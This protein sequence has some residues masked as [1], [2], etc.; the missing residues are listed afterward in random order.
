MRDR[1]VAF[2]LAKAGVSVVGIDRS[3][4]MLARARRRARRSEVAGPR[5]P[6]PRRHPAPAVPGRPLP[7]GD[8]A[9]T[10]SC[11]R[12]CA[13]GICGHARLGGGR[14]G[15]G[16]H[17]GLELVADLPSWEEYRRR[18]ACAAGRPAGSRITLV[19]SVRQ[20]RARRL[21]L[22][23]QEFI[24]RR[25][26][27]TRRRRF[28]L[29]FRTLSVPQMARRLEKAGFEV[30]STLGDYHGGPLGPAGRRLDPARAPPVTR[31]RRG[32]ASARRVPHPW[33]RAKL[34]G[35]SSC[36]AIPSGTPSST[37]RARLTPS[38]AR[39]SRASSRS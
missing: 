18:S 15:A 21:T 39:S 17:L 35:Q 13:S 14:P 37:R 36:P 20:D 4:E 38:A 1:P 28:T 12:C 30:T 33:A 6:R 2:P 7:T 23:D 29:A 34:R 11:S 27:D 26:R 10:A 3:A 16:R 19:E 32:V 22:F 24:E 31:C 8:R 9:R 5:A 25:G